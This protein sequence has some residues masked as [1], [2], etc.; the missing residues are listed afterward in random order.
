MSTVDVIIQ[1]SGNQQLNNKVSR[2]NYL[3]VCYDQKD[4]IKDFFIT[5]DK[6]DM[7]TQFVYGKGFFHKSHLNQDVYEEITTITN[8]YADLVSKNF[9]NIE[10]IYFPAHR[11]FLI[12][13]LV[14]R[15]K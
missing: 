6:P 14:F 5:L 1:Q 12:K 7:S 2:P 4:K 10:E 9:K 15:A 11:I 3:I 8:N 13:N